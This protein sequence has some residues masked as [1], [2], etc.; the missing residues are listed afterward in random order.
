MS[1]P[2]LRM[3]DVH[4]FYGQSYVLHGVSLDVPTGSV[5]ALLG[6]NGAGKTTT[7]KSIMGVLPT[8]EGQIEF[9]GHSLQGLKPHKVARLGIAYLPETRGVFPSLSVA[10][11]L[12]LVAG[13]RCGEWDLN[14]V[15]Q[16]FPRLRE[17][18]DH[19]ANQLSGGEQQMLALA[20]SLLMNP[21]LLIL[22][23]PTEGLAPIIVRDIR[24]RLRSLKDDGM[25][26]LLVEQSFRFAID[27]A[28]TAYVLGRGQIRWNGQA[29]E[30]A[31]DT[32]I[33]AQW[34]GV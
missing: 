19:G 29:N 12:N 5:V 4:A 1:T 28:D 22:D 20:R 8:R 17:R 16:A 9:N 21:E 33:Q 6:R 7:L 27:L 30:L 3:R 25:T 2:L 32:D 15:Y 23:E 34:I 11:N 26:I 10:E 31:R 14:R 18:I 13:R 24:D